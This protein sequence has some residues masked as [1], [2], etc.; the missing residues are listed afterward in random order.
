MNG[1]LNGTQILTPTSVVEMKTLQFGSTEQC[2]SFYYELIN[3]NEYLGHSG[4]EKGAT[5]EM[6][7]DKDANIGIIVFSNEEDAPLDNIISLLFNYGKK[8]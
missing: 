3:D 5:A 8:Q 2:L 1:S 4:G 6:Y 7:F